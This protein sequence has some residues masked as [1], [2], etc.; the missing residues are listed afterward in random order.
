M[1]SRSPLLSILIPNAGREFDDIEKLLQNLYDADEITLSRIEIIVASPIGFVVDSHIPLPIIWESSDFADAGPAEKRN[2]LISLAKGRFI[3]FLDADDRLLV[4]NM[5]RLLSYLEETSCDLLITNFVEVSAEGLISNATRVP[6]DSHKFAA[7]KL[8]EIFEKVHSEEFESIQPWHL[9]VYRLII[10]RNFL[11]SHKI[12]FDNFLIAE[13]QIFALDLINANPITGFINNLLYEHK[14]HSKSIASSRDK[15]TLEILVAA[16][17]ILTARAESSVAAPAQLRELW[18]SKYGS[19]AILLPYLKKHALDSQVTR[20]IGLGR[21]LRLALVKL[22]F[23]TMRLL[24]EYSPLLVRIIRSLQ[25]RARGLLA[26]GVPPSI[27]AID[28]RS[29]FKNITL[30]NSSIYPKLKIGKNSRCDAKITFLTSDSTVTVGERS[31]IGSGRILVAQPADIVFEDDIQFAD[32]FELILEIPLS[33]RDSFGSSTLDLLCENLF[34]RGIDY[35]HLD[36]KK[37]KK[38]VFP[39]GTEIKRGEKIDVRRFS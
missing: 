22:K 39:S 29:A 2:K 25:R 14:V 18:I 4:E 37:R 16:N 15:N 27:L 10:S 1:H 11:N 34:G 8:L 17:N 30:H 9:Q 12:N 23:K 24:S 36:G 32:D 26:T 38:I 20:A 33:E 3:W 21:F 19:G 5:E 7:T 31:T 28:D 6:F 35:L 13:D